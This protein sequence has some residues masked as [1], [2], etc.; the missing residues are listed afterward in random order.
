MR[1]GADVDVHTLRSSHTMI[2]QPA[3]TAPV[4]TWP[5]SNAACTVA[6]STEKVRLLFVHPAGEPTL[7]T[8][9]APGAAQLALY[10]SPEKFTPFLEPE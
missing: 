9:A 7:S 3:A 2:A 6:L 1:G 4:P 10:S 8:V 5:L